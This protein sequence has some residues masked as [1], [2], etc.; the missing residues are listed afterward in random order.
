MDAHSALYEAAIPAPSLPF[1]A[2]PIGNLA[3]Y[4]DRYKLSRGTLCYF[5]VGVDRNMRVSIVL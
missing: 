4:S 5:S 3:V 2:I 1:L